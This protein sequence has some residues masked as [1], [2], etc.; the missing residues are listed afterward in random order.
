M[1]GLPVSTNPREASGLDLEAV[2]NNGILTVRL[3]KTESV[4][5]GSEIEIE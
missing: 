1:T 3:P 4:E 2:H 5:D